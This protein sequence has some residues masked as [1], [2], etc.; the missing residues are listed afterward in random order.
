MVYNRPMTPQTGL[1]FDDVLIIPR[2][3]EVLPSAVC[4]ETKLTGNIS[5][6]VPLMSA[7]MDTVTDARLAIALAQ[8]GGIGMV[9]KNMSAADQAAQVMQVK[10]FESGVIRNPITV[11][12]TTK[13]GELLAI[14]SRHNISGVPVV[15]GSGKLVGIVTKRDLRFETK[16]A[17]EVSKVM[18]PAGKLVTVVEGTSP[19]QVVEL[20]REHRIEKVPVVDEN[21]HV[22]GLITVKDIQ[23]AMEHPNACR[24]LAER[25]RVGAAVGIGKGS[26]ERVEALVDAGV[27]VVVVDTAHGHSK[28]VLAMVSWIKSNYGQIALVGGNV[29][30]GDGAVALVKA[31]VD[32]V[33]VGI[34]PGSICTT[35]VVSG[36]GMPQVSAISEVNAALKGSAATIIADGGIRYS[37]DIAKALAAGAHSVM[38]GGL[39]AGTEEAP[40]ETEL[41]QGRV[42]KSYRGMGSLGAMAGTHGSADRY[43]QEGGDTSKMIPEGIEGRVPYKGSINSVLTQL[44]GGLR[45]AMGYTGCADIE[46]LRSEARFVRLTQAGVRE[47]HVHDV[48]MTK[49]PPNYHID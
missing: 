45:S 49:E 23:K 22:S 40:G 4:L 41:F 17:N 13:I 7:A 12:P 2:Y 27:D 36:I 3:S 43:F 47:S 26:Y 5:L 21:F 15:D 18:T 20:M 8:V 29:A 19:E 46:Q 30:T 11:S 14:S 16:M 24:D 28:G 34:G 42:Y 35:R 31:G 44:L 32:A 6:S 1:T 38:I 37:G 25:L 39:F 9:H 10:K 48:T 33:K